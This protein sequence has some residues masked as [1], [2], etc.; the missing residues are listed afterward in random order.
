MYVKCAVGL[1]VM[2]LLIM[3]AIVDGVKLNMETGETIA[4]FDI[5]ETNLMLYIGSRFP[6]ETPRKA[7]DVSCCNKRDTQTHC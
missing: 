1:Y 3:L 4:P 7:N 5:L 6:D 2:L